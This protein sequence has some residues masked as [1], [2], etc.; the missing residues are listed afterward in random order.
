VESLSWR[1]NTCLSW[2]RGGGVL[3]VWNCIGDGV[4]GEWESECML[5]DVHISRTMEL[6]KRVGKCHRSPMYGC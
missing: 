2:K 1:G 3:Y 6:V 4:W 5:K